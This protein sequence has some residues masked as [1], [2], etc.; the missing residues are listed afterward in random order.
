MIDGKSA[1]T[2]VE[3]MDWLPMEIT[4]KEQYSR[5]TFYDLSVSE[6]SRDILNCVK[7][8]TLS[9]GKLV[10]EIA[11]RYRCYIKCFYAVMS[12]EPAIRMSLDPRGELYKRFFKGKESIDYGALTGEQGLETTISIYFDR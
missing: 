7:D 3:K 5:E 1:K 11:P 4:V 8:E 6:N 2:F 9:S 10:P 12:D